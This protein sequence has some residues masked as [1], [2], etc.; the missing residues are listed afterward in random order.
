MYC[1]LIV[2]AQTLRL[3]GVRRLTISIPEQLFS[4]RSV[5]DKKPQKSVADPEFPREGANPRKGSADLL[6]G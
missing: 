4:L 2:R 6:F 5:T 1:Q 3:G